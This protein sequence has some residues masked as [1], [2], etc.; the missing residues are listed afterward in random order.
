MKRVWKNLYFSLPHFLELYLHA[1]LKKVCNSVSVAKL[2][3]LL[4]SFRFVNVSSYSKIILRGLWPV[5]AMQHR[6][7]PQR[8]L[9][10]GVHIL[11]CL[12]SAIDDSWADWLLSDSREP[13][14]S[15]A[16]FTFQAH[17]RCERRLIQSLL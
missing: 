16:H 8:F 4:R 5:P 3:A 14:T 15:A 10:S 17:T 13:A 9:G 11:E 7:Q 12:A 6:E 2:A 1:F